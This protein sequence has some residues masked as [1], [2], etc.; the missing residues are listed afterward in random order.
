MLDVVANHFAWTGPANTTDYSTYIPFNDEKYFHPVLAPDYGPPPNQTS[1]EIGWLVS[2][3]S[4]VVLPDVN[5]TREDV[6]ELYYAWIEALV[7]NYS[8]DGIRIDTVKHVEQSFWPEFNKRAGVYAV[9]EVFET[10][11]VTYLCDYQNYV[12]AVLN[13]GPFTQIQEAFHNSSGS[14]LALAARVQE[15][16]QTCK[17]PTVLGSFMENHDNPRFPNATED[18]VLAANAISFTML[19]DGIPIIY[20]LQEQHDTGGQDPANRDAAWLTG[21]NQNS[22]LYKLITKL[23]AARSNAIKVEPRY[24]DTLSQT[25]YADANTLVMRKGPDDAA[26]IGVFSNL[27][28]ANAT[29]YTLQVNGLYTGY[30][31]GSNLTEVLSCKTILVDDEGGIAVSMTGG[32]PMVFYPTFNLNGIC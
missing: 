7:A 23:N 24:L 4:P 30:S 21:Y 16:Q 27:G 1:I 20:Y 26:I 9:G 31:P 11:N 2:E 28:T 17:D 19:A 12:D 22:T 6:R 32:Q 10:E 13:Y 29:D 18:I 25:I 3:P 15:V 5:T 8:A 14:M